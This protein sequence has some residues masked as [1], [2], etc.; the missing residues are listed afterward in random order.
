MCSMT[1]KQELLFANIHESSSVGWRV[2]AGL[3]LAS[4]W[5]DSGYSQ[6]ADSPRFVASDNVIVAKVAGA[7]EFRVFGAESS[8]WTGFTFP[9]GVT[10][11][12]VV[13]NSGL[14]TF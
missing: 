12:P 10:A 13:S 2:M 1:V 4:L 8:N 5:I 14:C 11:T 9:D 6:V 7:N 3:C